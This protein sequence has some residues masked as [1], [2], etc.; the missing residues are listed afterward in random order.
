MLMVRRFRHPGGKIYF[1][2]IFNGFDTKL[3]KLLKVLLHSLELFRRVSLL[4]CNLTRDPKR[5]R[6]TV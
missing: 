2:S 4:I 5:I 1:Y 6:G 3:L